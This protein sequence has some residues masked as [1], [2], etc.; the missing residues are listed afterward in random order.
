M[1]HAY[2]LGKDDLLDDVL[3]GR[4]AVAGVALNDRRLDL[5]PGQ[6]VH[7]MVSVLEHGSENRSQHRDNGDAPVM[8]A[9]QNIP[10]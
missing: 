2:G 10:F 8:G 7:P 5:G 9:V 3:P 1:R 4:T 6:D